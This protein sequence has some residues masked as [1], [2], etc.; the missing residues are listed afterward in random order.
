MRLTY[1]SLVLLMGGGALLGVRPASAQSVVTPAVTY[2][3]L[4]PSPATPAL[5][6]VPAEAGTSLPDRITVS[7]RPPEVV[8]LVSHPDVP[9]AMAIEQPRLSAAVAPAT[10]VDKPV[11]VQ[12]SVAQMGNKVPRKVLAIGT[13]VGVPDGINLVLAVEPLYWVRLS[14]AGGSN[15]SSLGYRLGLTLIPLGFGPSLSVEGGNYSVTEPNSV[16]R[17]FF[18]VPTWV[19][20]YVQQIGYR[21]LNAQLG[22]DLRVGDFVVYLHGGYSYIHG[23]VRSPQAVVVDGSTGSSVHMRDDGVVRAY[24]WSLKAALMYMF[25]GV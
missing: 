10:Q 21:Y 4:R 1:L 13:D 16:V 24:T 9:P 18:E 25:A 23:L 22:W 7:K 2:T 15:T 12:S 6:T 3:P 20:P 14:M 11:V 5:R 8:S 17:K 19:E